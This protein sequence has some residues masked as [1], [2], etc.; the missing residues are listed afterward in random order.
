MDYKA[1]LDRLAQAKAV[2]GNPASAHTPV[3]TGTWGVHTV[4]RF[5]PETKNFQACTGGVE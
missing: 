2:Y 3:A 1:L 4:E 5:K